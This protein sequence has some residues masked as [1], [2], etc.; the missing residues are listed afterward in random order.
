[1]RGEAILIIAA[2]SIQAREMIIPLFA[3]GRT[4]AQCSHNV[5]NFAK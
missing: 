2:D 5:W 3:S 1:M 4:E